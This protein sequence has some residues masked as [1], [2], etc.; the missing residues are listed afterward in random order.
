MFGYA[1]AVIDRFPTIRAGV[2]HATNLV[3]GPSSPALL[4]AYRAEQR[5]VSER[6]SASAIA[7]LPSIA[8]WST[9]ATSFQSV[10]P[11]RLRCSIWPT[12][13]VPSPYGSPP[14][15]SCSPTS[16]QPT[17]STRNP[18]KSSSSTATM[19]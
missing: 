18:A 3:N 14:A 15:L 7:E 13:P 17:A 10:M 1:D 8:A 4:E 2:I 6:L 12:S 5:N 9:S 16:E 11:C 19:S